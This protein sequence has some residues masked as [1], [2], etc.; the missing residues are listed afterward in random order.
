MTA[1]SR[2]KENAETISIDYE[3][4]SSFAKTV[5][6]AGRGQGVFVAVTSTVSFQVRNPETSTVTA[7]RPM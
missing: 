7:K 6:V 5:A 1:A 2:S 3:I 4:G